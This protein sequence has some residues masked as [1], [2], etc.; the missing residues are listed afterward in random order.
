MNK[1]I[2]C[3][4]LAYHN[5]PFNSTK[6]S[7][8][9]LAFTAMIVIFFISIIMGPYFIALHLGASEFTATS[10][11]IAAWVV[12]TIMIQYIRSF[13]KQCKGPS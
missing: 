13:L 8:I 2:T 6:E 3:C 9:E 12:E 5:E 1:F 10:I 4:K 7:I 11:T